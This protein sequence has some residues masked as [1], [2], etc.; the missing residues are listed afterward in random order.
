MPRG[1]RASFA[2]ALVQLCWEVEKFNSVEAWTAYFMFA[3][4]VLLPSPRYG[5]RHRA[6]YTEWTSSR[7]DTWMGPTNATFLQKMEIRIKMWRDLPPM[8][9]QLKDTNI[10][11]KI[12]ALIEEGRFSLACRSLTKDALAPK[13]AATANALRAKHPEGK[14]TDEPAEMPKSL[15]LD[16]DEILNAIRSFSVGSAGSLSGLR[17]DHLRDASQAILQSSVAE[18][19]CKLCNLVASGKACKRVQPFLA[20][21]SLTA[22]LKKDGGIRP[23]AVGDV[24]RRLTGKALVRAQKKELVKHFS[25]L[26]VG[27]A[28]PCGA[29]A[30]AHGWK[31]IM[32]L[33]ADDPDIVAV[34]VDFDNA[35]NNANRAEMLRLCLLHF[36]ELYG[37]AWYCYCEPSSLDLQGYDVPEVIL[38]QQGTQ[39]GCPFGSF[40]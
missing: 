38:S 40:L 37:F 11:C 2:R 24:L 5:K 30:V 3:K 16:P 33:F 18:M 4:C 15:V 32:E 22:L 36:P 6:F 28:V 26:Q 17:P 7:C 20:G 23:I 13:N 10:Y 25:P 9:S 31:I 34:K 8:K 19:I 21:G 39:Q 35:F 12:K 27:V 14:N 29:E 1:A